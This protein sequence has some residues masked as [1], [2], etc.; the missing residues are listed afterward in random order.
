MLA[1]VGVLMR[2][3]MELVSQVTD[4]QK[5]FAQMQSTLV[6][7]VTERAQ[8]REALAQTQSAFTNCQ[9]R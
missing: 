6:Q 9:L 8:L 5:T 3:H 1:E 4:I 2:A 7:S